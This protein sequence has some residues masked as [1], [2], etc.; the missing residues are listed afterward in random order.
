V[1]AEAILGRIGLVGLHTCINH[2]LV[3]KESAE[4][5]GKREEQSL[6]LKN[7]IF[8]VTRYQ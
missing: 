7:P 2:V 3:T 6:D 5:K 1:S 8:E 4:I